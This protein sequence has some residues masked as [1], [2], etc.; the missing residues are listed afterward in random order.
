MLEGVPEIHLRDIATEAIWPNRY[1]SVA[2][3]KGART[4]IARGDGRPV[5]SIEVVEIEVRV[6][7][8]LA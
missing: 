2:A 7:R 1:A 4:N 5:D 6:L 3:A 8:V